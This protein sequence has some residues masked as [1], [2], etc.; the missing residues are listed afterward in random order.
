MSSPDIWGNLDATSKLNVLNSCAT[1]VDL[2]MSKICQYMNPNSTPIEMRNL[3]LSSF[4]NLFIL[5][6][7]NR[8]CPEQKTAADSFLPIYDK[9]PILSI[10]DLVLEVHQVQSKARPNIKKLPHCLN[11]YRTLCRCF[12]NRDFVSLINLKA[13]YSIN[14][15]H[16]LL[17]LADE[18][19]WQ[20]F[21]DKICAAFVS[22]DSHCILRVFLSNVP[23]QE[24]LVHSPPAFDAFARIVNYWTVQ[25]ITLKEPIF[26]W[27]QPNAEVPGHLAVQDFLRS[28]L[29]SLSNTNFRN[30]GKARKFA[31]TLQRTGPMNGFD[32]TV[33]TTGTGRLSCCEI[34]KNA[35]LFNDAQRYFEIRK[36][37]LIRL[38]HLLDC[39]SHEKAKGN[40]VAAETVPL[41]QSPTIASTPDEVYIVS[42]P[43]RPKLD[44]PLI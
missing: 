37:E 39:V 8:I 3:R 19:C 41:S 32:V 18:E 15:V 1:A 5:S 7:K 17:W 30:L 31:N 13:D 36:F 23:I 21:V 12:F 14:F 26:N 20:S 28:P 6:E 33:K 25:S 35:Q 24:A 44:I 42:P 9:L 34:V 38:V 16:F 4:V 27:Q 10:M 43:K 29:Q 11:F 22:E 2:G 40:Q